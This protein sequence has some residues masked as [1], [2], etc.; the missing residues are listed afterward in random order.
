MIF[1]EQGTVERVYTHPGA[2]FG[3]DWCPGHVN[4]IATGC[5]D[6]NVRV[7]DVSS[8]AGSEPQYLLSGHLQRVF[9]VCWCVVCLVCVPQYLVFLLLDCA[10]DSSNSFAYGRCP[11]LDSLNSSYKHHT[12]SVIILRLKAETCRIP[13]NY[14]LLPNYVVLPL[15]ASALSDTSTW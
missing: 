3:C 9:H 4:I 11:S 13:G 1:S 14:V 15:K 6:R 7:F 10:L 8:A 12:C 2:L 5:Q